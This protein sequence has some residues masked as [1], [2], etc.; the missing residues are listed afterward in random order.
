[1]RTPDSTHTTRASDALGQ[2]VCF[3]TSSGLFLKIRHVDGFWLVFDGF[4][5]L[6]SSVRLKSRHLQTLL[7]SLDAHAAKRAA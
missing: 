6:C 3:T 1:M 4:Q 5:G 7:F 2:Y